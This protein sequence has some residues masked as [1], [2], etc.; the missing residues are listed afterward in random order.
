M[1]TRPHTKG[2][3]GSTTHTCRSDPVDGLTAFSNETAQR[4]LVELAA[5][6]DDLASRLRNAGLDVTCGPTRARCSGTR[7]SVTSRAQP[8]PW[9]CV[10]LEEGSAA[11]SGQEAHS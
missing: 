1:T 8:Q 3:Q 5:P 6:L 11:G 4:A 7:S 9:V 2:S 10:L